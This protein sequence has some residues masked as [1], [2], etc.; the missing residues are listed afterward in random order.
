MFTDLAFAEMVRQ[1]FKHGGRLLLEDHEVVIQAVSQSR[2]AE[3]SHFVTRMF[4]GFR[5]P[6]APVI[7]DGLSMPDFGAVSWADIFD[8]RKDR[9][10]KYFREKMD[11]L[12][13]ET[14]M[15][16]PLD[17]IVEIDLWEALEA[18]MPDS[19]KSQVGKI[20]VSFLS[21]KVGQILFGET[22][23][24][25]GKVADIVILGR[26]RWLDTLRLRSHGSLI[27]VK[28]ARGRQGDWVVS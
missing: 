14:E 16:V 1:K 8:L 4:G 5:R 23:A 2:I 25:L 27:F 21:E 17:K 13:K 3:K 7:L 28:H 26:E 20:A 15:P 12:S 18:S 19:L 11:D 24:Y 6:M 22:G 10:I 9:F